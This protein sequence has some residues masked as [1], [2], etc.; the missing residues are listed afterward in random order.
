ML[1][2]LGQL[3]TLLRREQAFELQ[4]G[5]ADFRVEIGDRDAVPQPA[6]LLADPLLIER[7]RFAIGPPGV[8]VGG[9]QTT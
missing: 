9:M 4:L 2:G 1:V 5:D 7:V 3:R 6:I 8:A